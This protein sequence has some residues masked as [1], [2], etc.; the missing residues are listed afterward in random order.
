MPAEW[1]PHRAT[2]ISWPHHEPDWPGKLGPIPWVYAEIVRVLAGHE[3]VEILCAS[4]EV[5][6]AARARARGAR[7]SPRPRPAARRADRSRLAA[8][9]RADRRP[10]RGR[11]RRAASTGRSTAGRSTT[12]GASTTHVGPR[13]SRRI[14]GPAARRAARR[15]GPARRIVLEGG[16]IEVNG[17][18]LAAR[19][20][21]VAA[22]RRA[23]AQPRP[24][25]RATT[26]AIFARLAG[27]RPDDLARRRAASATTRTGTSTTSRASS[28]TDTVV[29]A[30]E[31]DPARRESR[32]LDGQPAP[33]GD[34]AASGAAPLRIVTLPYPAAG[35]DERRAAAGQ[36]RQLLHR[37]RRRASCRPSTT[38][39]I[40]WRSRRSPS[41][42]RL[43]RSSASTPSIWCG[44]WARCTA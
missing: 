36:L 38:R 1:E 13:P 40:A 33:P 17:R 8:R 4:D 31:D 14:T 7:R 16:G 32:A 41:C 21:G 43:A 2:W 34:C 19:H 44:A 23:G 42:C 3:P 37:Q 25:P 10:R 24:R 12:T 15:D 22:E 6:A 11:P 5:R 20:R 29:L 27:R 35:H 28:A 26:S 39:T 9:L 30:V 18:G